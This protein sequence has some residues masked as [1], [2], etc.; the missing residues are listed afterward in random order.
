MN[1]S[2][3]TSVCQTV[4]QVDKGTDVRPVDPLRVPFKRIGPIRHAV[5]DRGWGPLI[6][7]S[8]HLPPAGEI[9]THDLTGVDSL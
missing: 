1:E 9:T 5:E 2:R 6:D 4:S 8:V 7:Q 3:A